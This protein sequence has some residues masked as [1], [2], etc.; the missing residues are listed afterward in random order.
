MKNEKNYVG[1]RIPKMWQIL[2]RFSGVENKP[3]ISEEYVGFYQNLVTIV[4][5][6]TEIL[7]RKVVLW[8]F[9]TSETSETIHNSTFRVKISVKNEIF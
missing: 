7:T 2:K 3:F 6:Y 1:F 4:I 9:V 5:F 8:C